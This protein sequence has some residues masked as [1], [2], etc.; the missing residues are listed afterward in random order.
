MTIQGMMNL[1]RNG[2]EQIRGE[3][4]RHGRQRDTGPTQ[5]WGDGWKRTEA[6]TITDGRKI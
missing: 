4:D 5:E 2:N 1:Q 6:E 3:G